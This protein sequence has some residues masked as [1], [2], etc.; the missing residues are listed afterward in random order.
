MAFLGNFQL[1]KAD[2]EAKVLEICVP[3][4]FCAPADGGDVVID[5]ATILAAAQAYVA[6]QGVTVPADLLAL[7]AAFELTTAKVGVYGK[8]AK[9]LAEGEVEPKSVLGTCATVLEATNPLVINPTGQEDFGLC[10][11]DENCDGATEQILAS[12]FQ[13]TI[14]EGGA[15]RINACVAPYIAPA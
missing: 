6:A 12:D 13:V 3:L 8:G 4:D 2:T 10:I 14:A 1:G 9:V 15:I 7:G 11:V 5:R